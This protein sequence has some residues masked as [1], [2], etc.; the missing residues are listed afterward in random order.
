MTHIIPAID[1]MGGR[2][3]R[4]HQG[5]FDAKTT[6]SDDP[7]AQAKAFSEEGAEWLHVVDLDGARDARQAHESTVAAMVSD[8]TMNV[9]TGG[10]IRE[11]A[12]V[13]ALLD[14]GV[15]RVVIGSLCVT[16]PD[17][18]KS[19]LRD[20]GPDRIVAALD[21]NIENAVPRPAMKG[22]T[23]L[24]DTSLWDVLDDYGDALTTVLVTDI[25][26]DGV[27]AGANVDLYR[28][29]AERRPDLDIITSGGV[30]TLDDVKALKALKPHGII[31]GKALYEGR[32]SV[33]EAIAC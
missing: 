4:L 8:T 13:Q 10:G 1:L 24:S 14:A 25:S 33:S 5:D 28:E 32:F 15:A 27:L 31:I 17:T 16:E 6:Y 18:V 9:Q 19:W 22:W 12:Q 23:E 21:V 7:L 30:G 3:V 26:R 2:C 20:F 11:R 29:M